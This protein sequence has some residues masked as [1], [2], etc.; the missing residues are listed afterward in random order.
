MLR[1]LRIITNFAFMRKYSLVKPGDKSCR[2]YFTSIPLMVLIIPLRMNSCIHSLIPRR[3][4]IQFR[5]MR[6][7][8]ARQSMIFGFHRGRDEL[9][10]TSQHLLRMDILQ[11]NYRFFIGSA[12][13]RDVAES[14]ANKLDAMKLSH[15]NFDGFSI[16]A[17]FSL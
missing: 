16:W 14:K 13:P 3:I 15:N 17:S 9:H 5:R 2:P 10:N 4:V 11:P 8:V 1:Q 12:R 7:D 6:P